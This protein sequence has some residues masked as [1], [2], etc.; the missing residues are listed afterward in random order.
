MANPDYP[1]FGEVWADVVVCGPEISRPSRPVRWDRG[2]AR[3]R[4]REKDGKKDR[5]KKETNDEQ[6]NTRME[7]LTGRKDEPEIHNRSLE[8][9]RCRDPRVS[10]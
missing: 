3:M 2:G 9:H 4:E 6:T 5:E 1:A 10:P 7:D 8:C